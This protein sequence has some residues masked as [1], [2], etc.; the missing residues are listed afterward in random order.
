M[1]ED[2]E[3][4]FR[5]IFTSGGIVLVG[6][7][8]HL[9][10]GFLARVLIARDLGRVSYGAVSIGVTLLTTLSLLVLVGMDTGVGRYLPRYDTPERRRGVLVS[11]FQLVVPLAVLA[12]V[13]LVVLAGPLATHVFDDPS[14]APIL[15]VFGV[16]TPLAAVVN[17]TVGSVRG[18]QD[19]LPRV[20]IKNVAVPLGR[21]VFIAAVL[22]AGYRSVG[23]AW[24]YAGAYA[25]ATV[26]SLYYLVR[27][28]PLFERLD[29]EPMH[30]ELLAF[31]AP[32]TVTATMLMLFQNID[33]LMLG[34]LSS[35]GEV[36]IYTA[37]YP[38]A[39]LLT[40]VLTS[41]GFLFMP[42][43]SDLHAEEDREQMRRTFEVV[44]KWV[45]LTTLPVFLV[46]VTFPGTVIGLT[47]GAEYTDGALA[48]VVLV[49]G[50]GMHAVAGLA[51]KALTAM[52]RSR[53][54]MYDTVLV[55]A[56]NIGLNLVLIPRYGVLGAAVATTVGYLVMDGL[57]LVQ[58][59]RSLAVHPLRG[60][61]LRPGLAAGLIWGLFALTT[62]T[63]LPRTLPVAVV[64]TAVFFLLYPVVVVAVGSVEQED[65]DLVDAV[66]EQLGVDFGPIRNIAKQLA[67]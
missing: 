50:F 12:G 28:T 51:G 66:E 61:L 57:Y 58:L 24:A 44:S 29:A 31:S 35:T 20:Y 23:V 67:G 10:L 59:H 60:A 39:T 42:V 64:G 62:G 27:H 54:I 30:R 47:F 53:I 8:L 48:L 7:V 1:P 52:G 2:S 22:L 45:F 13:A 9:G 55:A 5:R 46:Y 11:A 14:V 37:V 34:A 25:V 33:V 19:S 18:M 32:F 41:F 49:T 43:L 65:I 63:V 17:L 4:T 6:T 40:A 56:V 3:A 16:A 21:F 38:L 26:L 15:R 36:G